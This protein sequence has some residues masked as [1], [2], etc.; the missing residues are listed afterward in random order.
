MVELPVTD[1]AVKVTDAWPSVAVTVPMV[2]ASGG[3]AT[4]L[5]DRLTV[6]AAR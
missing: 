3:T 1:G 5:N 4:T 6:E 2:G